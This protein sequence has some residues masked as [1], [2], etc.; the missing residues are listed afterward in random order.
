MGVAFEQLGAVV[1]GAGGDEQIVGWRGDACRAA[2]LRKRVRGLPHGRIDRENFNVGRETSDQPPLVRPARAG[3]E[4]EEDHV[5]E[6]GVALARGI[7]DGAPDERVA[8][9][10]KQLDP[11]GRVDEATRAHLSARL[12][13]RS[14]CVMKFFIVP[15]SLSN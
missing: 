6:N 7:L 8:G 12:R 1:I 2:R 15:K 9:R 5:T 4:L 10:A 3:P 11:C 13:A 14:S